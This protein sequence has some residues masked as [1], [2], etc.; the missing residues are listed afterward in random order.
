MHLGLISRLR[1]ILLS[2][3]IL[4]AGTMALTACGAGTP[5]TATTAPK[6]S[7]TIQPKWKI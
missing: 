4:L 2:L 1:Q 6:T 3:A 7:V 5:A